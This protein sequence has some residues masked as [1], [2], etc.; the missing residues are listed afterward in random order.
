MGIKLPP[1]KQNISSPNNIDRVGG[2]G[3]RAR[4]LH[5]IVCWALDHAS[6][7]GPSFVPFRTI[8]GCQ[9]LYR[10]RG[11]GGKLGCIAGDNELSTACEIYVR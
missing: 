5:A 9:S 6:S 2:V 11:G 10:G 3:G 1:D 4:V 8:S 7:G